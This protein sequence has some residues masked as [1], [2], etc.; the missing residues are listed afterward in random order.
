MGDFHQCRGISRWTGVSVD[1][2]TAVN[3]AAFPGDTALVLPANPTV[4][5]TV[6]FTNSG[7]V[8]AL[9]FP[10]ANVSIDTLQA[11]QPKPVAPNVPKTFTCTSVGWTTS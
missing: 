6:L 9:I 2:S 11:S 4:G 1:G 7:S 8:N 10:W 5:S 3:C